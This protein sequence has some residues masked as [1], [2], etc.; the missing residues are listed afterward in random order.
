MS[1]VAAK[2]IEFIVINSFEIVFVRCLML[3]MRITASFPYNLF[4]FSGFISGAKCSVVPVSNKIEKNDKG[5]EGKK[6]KE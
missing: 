5:N 1:L 4:L 2:V 6:G 3:K